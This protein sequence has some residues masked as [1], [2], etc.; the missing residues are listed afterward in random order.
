MAASE[1]SVAAGTAEDKLVLVWSVETCQ[2]KEMYKG[3]SKI[4][5]PTFV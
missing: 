2:V 4:N 3:E 1:R 5:Q